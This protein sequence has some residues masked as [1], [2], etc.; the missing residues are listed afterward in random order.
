M[1]GIFSR[2]GLGADS[3]PNRVFRPMTE[4]DVPAVLEIIYDHDEDDG[5]EAE[6]VFRDSLADKYVMEFEGRMMGMTG[7][8]V[9]TH[10]RNTAWLSFTYVHSFFRSNGNG[11]WMMLELRN[12]L[13]AEGI[14]RLFIATS[15]YKDEDTGE[16][17]Y[18]P[19]R[20]FY[21]KK[22][23]ARRDLWVEDF[24]APGEWR[25]VYSLPV[26]ERSEAQSPIP[27]EASARFIG[28]EEVEESE[29]SYI[30]EWEMLP[31][32]EGEKAS[33][34]ETKTLAQLIEEVDSYNGKTLF[35]TLPDIVSA[36]HE[37]ELKVAG[38]K[39]IGSL[40]DYYSAGVDEV[41]WSRRFD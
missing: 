37:A 18:L 36:K 28:V 16:D 4:A 10:T 23:Q 41:W 22:L 40:G 8:R 12:V 32:E 11:Y 6:L 31:L 24:Y 35:V 15:D 2:L 26:S 9:D 34:F 14:E 1:A 38:F 17:I 21:E 39:D 5:E 29:Q 30:A 33:R 25:Y 27:E 3:G 20:N 7:Y 13:E 19:A